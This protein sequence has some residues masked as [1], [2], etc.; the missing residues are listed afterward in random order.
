MEAIDA[1]IIEQVIKDKGGFG[2]QTEEEET[3]PVKAAQ[4][5]G[6]HAEKISRRISRLETEVRKLGQFLEEELKER[7]QRQNKQ[8]DVQVEKLK[9]LLFRER[10]RSA[11]LLTK[12]SRMREKYLTLYKTFAEIDKGRFTPPPVRPVRQAQPDEAPVKIDPSILLPTDLEFPSD[13]KDFK[14]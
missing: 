6:K 11:V 7:K 5:P 3:Q 13:D 14:L 2:I 10:K 9:K 8:K 1:A 4:P 12:Y